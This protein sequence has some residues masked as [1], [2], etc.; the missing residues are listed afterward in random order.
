MTTRRRFLSGMSA[1]GL[2]VGCGGARPGPSTIPS[3]ELDRTALARL[4]EAMQGYLTRGELPG[5]V[6]LVSR[7]PSLHVEA[8]G[9]M[10]LEQGAAVA[11]DTL[12]R[13]SS[14]SKPVTAVAALMLIDE[15][16]LQL[17]EPVD[18]LLPELAER[19]V[20]RSLD[21]PLDDTVPAQRP[22]TVRDL[23]TFR[24]GFG[25]LMVPPEAYPITKAAN[26]L[27]IGMGPPAPGRMPAPDEWLKRLGSL[28][29]MAQP[30]ERWLYNTGSDVLGVL[31]ARAAQQDFAS[32]LRTRLFEPLGM[33]DTAFHVPREKLE[34][35]VTSY[36][37]DPAS[38]ARSL[39]DEPSGQWSAPPAFQSGAGGLVS[40]IDD[41]FAFARMLRQGG[42][43]DGARLLSEASLA[44]LRTDQLTAA[45]KAASQTS[46][47]PS[48]FND[49]GWGY[50]VSVVTHEG[51]GEPGASFGWDGGLGSTFR[52]APRED[53]V[54][55][56]LTQQAWTSPAPPPIVRDFWRGAL[57]A[58]VEPQRSHG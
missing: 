43:H 27:E 1:L 50:G 23:L 25:Q 3:A 40:T 41:Y 22:I 9:Y 48:Y 35:F 46:L 5:L 53:M 11:R 4:R 8:L 21:G 16:K 49:H 39:Y 52:V 2:A 54:I 26:S 6:A 42:E 15:G 13:I 37:T 57:A 14:M 18:R 45:Q 38:G 51:P 7:G 34:R 44:A 31:I 19:K 33:R 56:L 12:F 20:L 32:F 10:A 17:D 28:P 36:W 58:G 55:I 29:W 30:G 24:M 47:V